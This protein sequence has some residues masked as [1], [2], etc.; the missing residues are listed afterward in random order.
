MSEYAFAPGH[1]ETV[2]M[3]DTEGGFFIS[4]QTCKSY[5]LDALTAFFYPE[6]A[7]LWSVWN[8]MSAHK[9]PRSH[10]NLDNPEFVIW[11]G[12]LSRERN[13]EKLAS[14]LNNIEEKMGIDGRSEVIIPDTGMSKGAGPIVIKAPGFWVRSPVAVSAMLLFIRLAPRLRVG[15]D[16]DGFMNRMSDSAITNYRDA[17]YIRAADERGNIKALLERSM[18]CLHREGYSDYLLHAHGRGFA[19]YHPESDA[20]LPGDESSLKILRIDGRKA[21]LNRMG[22]VE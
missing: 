14:F 3:L 18:P 7:E 20:I 11:T 17:G 8:P 22:G 4:P 15:E 16:W 9:K 1:R 19:W 5:I 12:V 6:Y 2:A 10:P 13:A 21:E